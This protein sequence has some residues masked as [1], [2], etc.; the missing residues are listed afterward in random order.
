[1]AIGY[2]GARSQ[3]ML[4]Q[5][6]DT[7]GGVSP[8]NIYIHTVMK[9]VQPLLTNLF[10]LNY[11]KNTNNDKENSNKWVNSRYYYNIKKSA[12]VVIQN[13]EGTVVDARTLDSENLNLVVK[14]LAPQTVAKKFQG[15][16][17]DFDL[18][19]LKE[20]AS[21]AIADYIVQRRLTKQLEIFTEAVND[22]ITLQAT[23]KAADAN[24]TT[25]K[26]GAHA[27]N[28]TYTTAD[29]IYA[30]LAN[31]LNSFQRLGN[32][33]AYGVFNK[34]IDTAIGIQ[35]HD[36]II[37]LSDECAATLLEKPGLFASD[38]G[39]EL[40]Q[41]LDLKKI[42]G[43]PTLISSQ[44]PEGVNFMIITTG[45]CG[46]LGYEEIGEV[47]FKASETGSVKV[48]EGTAV[49][50]RDPQWSGYYRIDYA[51]S[52]KMGVIFE[53]FIF[54]STQN[55]ITP[56]SETQKLATKQAADLKKYWAEVEKKSKPKKTE[57]EESKTEE[58]KTE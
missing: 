33:N 4:L 25:F 48:M 45:R 22:A 47:V 16:F 55:S 35:K 46:A 9:E 44:L 18:P 51:E 38:A 41:K 17:Q 50:V 49:M 37:L 34:N 7:I 13:T 21:I 10:I 27:V 23:I 43:V 52:F 12:G 42:L 56:D 6:Q 32:A 30:D 3:S 54:V 20:T 40:F 31:A 1:M 11:I 29:E 2:S 15:A 19:G 26:T 24:A 14:Q 53:E 58:S 39:N 28:A 8:Q 57:T 36:M 5:V